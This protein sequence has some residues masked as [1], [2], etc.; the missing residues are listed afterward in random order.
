MVRIVSSFFVFR[1]LYRLTVSAFSS[2]L[3]YKT[4]RAIKPSCKT[5]LHILCSLSIVLKCNNLVFFAIHA[6]IFLFFCSFITMSFSSF[7]TRVPHSSSYS[8]NGIIFERRGSSYIVDD[9]SIPGNFIIIIF[10]S[11][12]CIRIH[13]HTQRVV[14]R[15]QIGKIDRGLDCVLL[16]MRH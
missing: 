1:V 5:I 2:C 14:S 9:R 15:V 16:Y 6:R 13:T 8:S 7:S 3:R 11:Y 12:S 4:K 10:F